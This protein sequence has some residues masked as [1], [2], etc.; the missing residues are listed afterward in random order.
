[1]ALVSRESLLSTFRKLATDPG[2]LKSGRCLER[3]VMAVASPTASNNVG[4]SAASPG[5]VP[6]GWPRRHPSTQPST[7]CALG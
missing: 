4:P 1:M 2:Q 7:G 3:T 5:S 6:T